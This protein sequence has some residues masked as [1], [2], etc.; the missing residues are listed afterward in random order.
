MRNTFIIYILQCKSYLN[1]RDNGVNNTLKSEERKLIVIKSES[2]E[3]VVCSCSLRWDLLK[4]CNVT[5][6]SLIES[7]VDTLWIISSTFQTRR[8]FSHSIAFRRRVSVLPVDFTASFWKRVAFST[9]ASSATRKPQTGINRPFKLRGI[10]QK[11]RIAV[12]SAEN[13]IEMPPHYRFRFLDTFRTIVY[14]KLG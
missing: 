7:L 3:F 12:N 11:R 5:R 6:P 1:T 10:S 14:I 2:L 8:S 9:T 13:T 4:W